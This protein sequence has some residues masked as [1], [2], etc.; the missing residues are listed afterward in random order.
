MEISVMPTSHLVTM[1]KRRMKSLSQHW[2]CILFTEEFEKAVNNF[3][4]AVDAF[5]TLRSLLKSEH[6]G[7]INFVSSMKRLRLPYGGRC[8]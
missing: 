2:K 4:S 6:H 8:Q 5:Y 7:K 1:E 3:V